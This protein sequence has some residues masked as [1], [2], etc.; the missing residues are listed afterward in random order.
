M[1]KSLSL[2]V[3]ERFEEVE[4]RSPGETSID[5]LPRVLNLKKELCEANVR[6]FLCYLLSF[7]YRYTSD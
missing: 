6:L 4:G 7:R 5:D 1:K 2:A 3:I